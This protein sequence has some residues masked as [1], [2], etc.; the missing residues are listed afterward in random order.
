MHQGLHTLQIALVAPI[1]GHLPQ[2][3]IH[4]SV[5]GPVNG[6]SL[7]VESPT[8]KVEVGWTNYHFLKYGPT[9][10]EPRNTTFPADPASS[11]ALFQLLLP[12]RWA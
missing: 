2:K 10:R 4:I 7:C 1:H 5:A 3:V 6:V 12:R 11:F 9:K 8:L